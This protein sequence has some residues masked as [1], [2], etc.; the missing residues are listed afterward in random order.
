EI[1]SF[2]GREREFFLE[3][4]RR[5]GLYRPMIVEEL[6]RAGMPEELSWLPLVESGFESRALS[7]ARALGLWQVIPS[8]GHRYGLD[9][10]DWADDRMAPEKATRAAVGYLTDL[11]GLFGAWLT[12]LAAYNRGETGVLRRIR[13]QPVAYFDR[14]WDLYEQLP[15]E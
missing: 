13:E 3:S 11:H 15:R 8:T 14:F 2:T 10:A 9:R 5:S 12:A 4:Y 6:R 7:S 1:A